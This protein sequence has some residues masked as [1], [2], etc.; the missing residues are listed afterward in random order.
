MGAVA[1][2]SKIVVHKV[3]LLCACGAVGML[4]HVF[5]HAQE[6]EKVIRHSLPIAMGMVGQAG[7]AKNPV[8]NCNRNC[9]LRSCRWVHT[10]AEGF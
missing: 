5:T 3:E 6:E 4:L 2:S 10:M 9:Q 7:Y 1:G 8:W